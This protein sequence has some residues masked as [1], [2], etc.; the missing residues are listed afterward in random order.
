MTSKKLLLGL[1]FL[2]QISMIGFSKEILQKGLLILNN[3]DST[4]CLIDVYDTNIFIYSEKIKYKIAEKTM[5]IKSSDVSMIKFNDL[6]YEKFTFERKKTV[7][8]GPRK[9]WVNYNEVFFAALVKK[10]NVKLYHHYFLQTSGTMNVNGMLIPTGT[11]LDMEYYVKKNDKLK[12]ISKFGF[13][14]DCIELFNDCN[15]AIEKIENRDFKYKT[16]ADLVDFVNSNC[17]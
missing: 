5:K 8:K 4:S 12:K 11:Y 9:V 14:N 3:G 2:T 7:Q 15:K 6:I 17:N 16:I 10:G 1:I 13:K